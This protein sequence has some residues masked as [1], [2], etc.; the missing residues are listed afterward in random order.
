MVVGDGDF[1]FSREV[2]PWSKHGTEPGFFCTFAL[3]PE[4]DVVKRHMAN[5]SHI[6]DHL[7]WFKSSCI[8]CNFGVD[9]THLTETARW[10]YPEPCDVILW[11]YPFPEN[12]DVKV[13]AKCALIAAFF[14]SVGAWQQFSVDGTVVLGLKSCSATKRHVTIDQDYQFNQWCI[15]EAAV[16][17]GFQ[18]CSTVRPIVPFWHP[19]H[20]SGRPLC[21]AKDISAGNVMI[22]YYAFRRI[23]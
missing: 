8:K 21:K 10:V 3:P 5:N 17:H 23:P 2:A 18:L 4:E 14:K 19:T 12:N 22:K 11:N 15:G 9:A 16:V 20:V 13:F 6:K 1:S 7:A